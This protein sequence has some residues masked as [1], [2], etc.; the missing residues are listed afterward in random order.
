MSQVQR[1]RSRL[2]CGFWRRLAASSG[3]GHR[4]G[5]RTRRRAACAT[6]LRG[7]RRGAIR[8]FR[9]WGKHPILSNRILCLTRAM[10][11]PRLLRRPRSTRV[12]L[13]PHSQ[14]TGIPIRWREDTGITIRIQLR[15]DKLATRVCRQ[16]R[17]N[18]LAL[19]A[20]AQNLFIAKSS[21]MGS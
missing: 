5:A 16:A 7:R 20:E 15:P 13:L 4:D 2:G 10:R 6:R 18:R 3:N 1:W 9:A 19:E 8:S 11:E 17:D 12:Q 21:R 14:P